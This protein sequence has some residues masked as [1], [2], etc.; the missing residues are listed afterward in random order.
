VAEVSDRRAQAP[1]LILGAGR[2]GR[3]INDVCAALGRTV[4]GFLDDTRAIGEI[5]NGVEVIGGFA[6]AQDEDLIAALAMIVGVGDSAARASIFE[7][8]CRR[9]ACLTTIIHPTCVISPSAEIG[10]GVFVNAYTRIMANARVAD[11]V[12]IEGLCTI[13][14]DTRIEQSASLGPGCHLTAGVALGARCFL[15][16]GALVVGRGRVGCDSVIGAGATVLDPIADRAFGVG[17]PARVK[18]L[19]P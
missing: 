18:R 9:G 11:N 10:R 19:L 15:G 6:R 12:L 8:L 4:H 3:N 5:V 7:T 13:G 2:Q 17:T 1:V 14:A 16:A